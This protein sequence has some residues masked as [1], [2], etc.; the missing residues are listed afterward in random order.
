MN[1]GGSGSP[2]VAGKEGDLVT[3]FP[4]APRLL[5]LSPSGH[6]VSA[7]ALRVQ[8]LVFPP[9]CPWALV[10]TLHYARENTTMIRHGALLVFE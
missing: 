3:T 4:M 5:S 1:T 10:L 6:R 2:V 8:P 7:L 9:D